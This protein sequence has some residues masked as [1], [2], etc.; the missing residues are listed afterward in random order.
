MKLVNVWD[1]EVEIFVRSVM[2]KNPSGCFIHEKNCD[3]MLATDY[4]CRAEQ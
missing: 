2:V 4:E 1:F 3:V